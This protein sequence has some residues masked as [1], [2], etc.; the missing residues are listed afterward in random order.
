MVNL[1][2]QIK[3]KKCFFPFVYFSNDL[4]QNVYIGEIRTQI[5]VYEIGWVIK[6]VKAPSITDCSTG[7][8]SVLLSAT[9]FGISL[10]HY[11]F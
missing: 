3:V 5:L 8:M 7:C 9:R 1:D 4:K 6:H 11:S 2:K 10:Q